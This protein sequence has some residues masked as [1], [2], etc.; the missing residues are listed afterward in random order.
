VGYE[1]AHGD[2]GKPTV[3]NVASPP[4][5]HLGIAAPIAACTQAAACIQVP[6]FTIAH[7]VYVCEGQLGVG[8]GSSEGT[9]L[10]GWVVSNRF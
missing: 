4:P 9:V 1:K 7:K 5:P 8:Q 10:E 3:D 6:A 2:R